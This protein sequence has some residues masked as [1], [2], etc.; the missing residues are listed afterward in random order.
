M[1]PGN[2]DRH[3][4]GDVIRDNSPDQRNNQKIVIEGGVIVAGI[5]AMFALMSFGGM[6]AMAILMPSMI[7]WGGKAEAA[8]GNARM[9]ITERGVALVT[10]D[11]ED[12]RR[13]L[14]LHNIKVEE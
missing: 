1:N 2:E 5:A 12:I 11:L 7:Q 8:P 6:L 9:Q 3:D 4:T 10:D 13:A 14:A